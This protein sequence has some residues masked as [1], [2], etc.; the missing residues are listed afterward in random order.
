MRR[1]RSAFKKLR[2]T[3]ALSACLSGLAQADSPDFFFKHWASGDKYL[4]VQGGGAP[5]HDAKV[6]L[7]TGEAGWGILKYRP[8]D[9]TWGLLMSSNGQYCL[10]PYGNDLNAEDG[11]QLAFLNAGACNRPAAFWHPGS[12][13]EGSTWQWVIQHRGGKYINPGSGRANAE[14]GDRLVLSSAR[15]NASRFEL[16]SSGRNL[17]VAQ[18]FGITAAA[19][20]S[21]VVIEGKW[22]KVQECQGS[23]CAN[24]EHEITIGV[25]NGKE[26]TNSTTFGKAVSIM[27]GG[28]A[29]TNSGA[30][31][32]GG[33]T[34]EWSV[35]GSFSREDAKTVANSFSTT[36]NSASKVICQG[37]HVLWQW[38]TTIRDSSQAITAG[39]K[40]NRCASIGAKPGLI[41]DISWNGH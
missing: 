11:T 38:F 35:T 40:I 16:I 1:F 15:N 13:Q 6:V 17:D 29:T 2:Y 36:M 23:Q 10:V 19:A 37:E 31:P 34:V 3:V 7:Y 8:V 18:I 32:G 9:E 14:D 22:E 39:S 24:T 33:A 41:T 21:N 27:V 28:S 26:V 20:P 4:H 12:I 5:A 25:E 30:L